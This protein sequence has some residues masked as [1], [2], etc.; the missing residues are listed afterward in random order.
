MLHNVDLTQ[1]RTVVE[2]PVPESVT[3][4]QQFL[5]TIIVLWPSLLVYSPQAHKERLKECQKAFEA[6]KCKITQ[7][8]VLVYP[9]ISKQ[10]ILETDSVEKV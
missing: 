1:V 9:D 4:V 3:Q 5:D 10:F 8:P 7:A 6:L 2:F